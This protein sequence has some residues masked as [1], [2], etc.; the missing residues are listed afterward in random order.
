MDQDNLTV[1]ISCVVGAVIVVVLIIILIVIMLIV[2]TLRKRKKGC[3]NLQTN[4]DAHSNQSNVPV[5]GVDVTNPVYEGNND[6]RIF[7][8]AEFP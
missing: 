2:F 3:V 1:I 8:I 7:S 4:S 5:E 6:I